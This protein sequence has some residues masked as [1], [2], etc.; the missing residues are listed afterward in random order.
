MN[1]D[2]KIK[3][4][5]NDGEAMSPDL[6]IKKQVNP[7]SKT[8]IL[9][10]LAICII[11]IYFDIIHWSITTTGGMILLIFAASIRIADQWEKAVVLRMGKFL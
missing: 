5:V 7:I 4:Q 9:L 2:K 11:L 8:I 1:S 3:Q 10:S 6:E